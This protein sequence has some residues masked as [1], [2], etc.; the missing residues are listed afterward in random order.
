ML[1]R[2]MAEILPIRRKTLY[3]QPINQSIF[4][5]HSQMAV[6]VMLRIWNLLEFYSAPIEIAS[7]YLS[8]QL[9]QLVHHVTSY[10]HIRKWKHG[11]R[12][13]MENGMITTKLVSKFIFVFTSLKLIKSQIPVMVFL[14]LIID[15]KEAP[16]TKK[17]HSR[18][19][20]WIRFRRIFRAIG[21]FF[22]CLFGSC[23]NKR[24]TIQSSW[25]F[26][27]IIKS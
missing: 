19:K 1:R 25:I 26:Q 5:C 9:S 21:R 20:R 18:P 16:D 6:F 13:T 10:A 7:Q 23:S 8:P 4:T 22:T 11:S 14:F 24:K 27:E 12:V 2:Y 3:N 17:N 15:C